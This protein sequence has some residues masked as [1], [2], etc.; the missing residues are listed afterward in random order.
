MLAS[1]P[2]L[3]QPAP[4][5]R[6]AATAAAIALLSL[7]SMALG[8]GLAFPGGIG[9]RSGHGTQIAP[10]LVTPANARAGVSGQVPPVPRLTS[11][12]LTAP[13]PGATRTV[14]APVTPPPITTPTS[15]PV[16]VDT[17]N[18]TVSDVLGNLPPVSA[19]RK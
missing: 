5:P 14:S 2:T 15:A 12:N 8:L 7:A 3:V 19:T 1:F 6:R 17:V 10:I 13:A 18:Q 4:L 9:A 16:V 11:P